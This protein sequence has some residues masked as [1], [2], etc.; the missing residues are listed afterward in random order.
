MPAT[1]R[2]HSGI[3][4]LHQVLDE[5]KDNPLGLAIL[6]STGAGCRTQTT[7]HL[8]VLFNHAGKKLPHYVGEPSENAYVNMPA[9]VY[10]PAIYAAAR[11]GGF[12]RFR[13]ARMWFDVRFRS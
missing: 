2:K 7:K 5:N 11:K 6:M 13:S 12:G 10:A 3:A 8:H 9:H 4:A 1:P